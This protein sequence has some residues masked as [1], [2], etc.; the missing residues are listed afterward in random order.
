MVQV[1][2]DYTF[3]LAAAYLMHIIFITN[4][5]IGLGS[6]SFFENHGYALLLVYF[7]V[8]FLFENHGS[9]LLVK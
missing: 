6:D 3:R 7:M 9:L 8:V 2:C 1:H 4:L 5:H